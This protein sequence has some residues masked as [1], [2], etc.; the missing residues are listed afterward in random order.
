MR[1]W[2]VVLI[3]FGIVMIIRYQMKSRTT[4]KNVAK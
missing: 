3:I 1:Y 4:D 2:P